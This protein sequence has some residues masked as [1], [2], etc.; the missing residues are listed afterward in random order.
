MEKPEIVIRRRTDG[1]EQTYRMRRVLIRMLE[2]LLVAAALAAL[3]FGWF[4]PVR[5]TGDSMAPALSDGEIVL[6]D[7]L[8]RYWKLPTRG[9]MIAFTTEE[10]VFIKRIVALPGERVEIVDGAVFINSVPLDESLYAH[11]GVDSL[12]PLHVPS[13]SVFVLGD[14]RIK[15]YDSRLEAVGCIPYTEITG[16]PRVRISPVSRWT[17]FF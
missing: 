4:R 16:V 2:V 15:I 11:G 10:G 12:A 7:R 14:N 3:F 6:C 9:D 8:A 13:G 5:I 1:K 17:V